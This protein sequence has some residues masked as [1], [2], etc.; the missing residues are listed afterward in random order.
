M[1]QPAQQWNA[2]VP[3]LYPEPEPGVSIKATY[4][5]PAQQQE[6]VRVPVTDNTY[7]YAKSLAEAIFKQHFA[8]DEHYASGQIVWGVN[9]TVIGILTQINNM[10]ADM[11][12]RP[13][14]Q[15]KEGFASPGGGYVPAIPRPIPLD[16]KLVPKKATPEMLRAMD[17]CAQEG[18][19]ERLYEGMASSVYM[20]AWDASPVLGTL[21]TSKEEMS[22]MDMVVGNLVREGINKHRARELADHFIKQCN[23]TNGYCTGRSDLLAEQKAHQPVAWMYDIARY[24]PTD[25]RG[26]QWR[27]AISR[28]KPNIHDSLVRY[29]TP[30]YTFPSASK[31]WV[32]LTQQDIDIAFDDTQ[33]GGG[34]DEFARAIEAKLKEK[35][36]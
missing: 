23:Y 11:V 2:G 33:E 16:W 30:L 4:D 21:P 9:D 32:G 18:Y 12:R 3:S 34:F 7:N 26:Q 5:Q 27:P 20:A 1:E 31:P 28:T 19:D 10:V 35:N 36:T 29:M 13:A 25:L 6:P 8:S 15:Q 24:G 17:E 22:M 14:Q